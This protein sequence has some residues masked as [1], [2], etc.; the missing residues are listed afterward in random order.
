M[1]IAVDASSPIRWTGTWSASDGGS[2]TSA[3]FTAPADALLVLCGQADTSSTGDGVLTG[4]DS[5]GLTWTTRIAR[6][7]TES[8]AGGNS[9]IATARTVSAVSRTVNLVGND[10]GGTNK[11]GTGRASAKLYVLTGVDVDGTP[12]DTVG[13]GNE[14]FS[15]TNDMTTTSITPGANGLLIV[16]DCEW[17]ALGDFE[18]SSDLTQDSAHYASAISVCSGYKTCTSGVG[19]T[20]N[21]NANGSSAAHHKW[22]QVTVREAAAGGRTTKNTRSNPLGIEIGMNLRGAA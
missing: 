17:N 3:A 18:A 11:W 22:C 8:T 5:G 21:L 4:T 7:G 15:S 16:S 9:V 2:I 10:P 13:A 19:V 20:G 6:T 1:A 14:G 12:V